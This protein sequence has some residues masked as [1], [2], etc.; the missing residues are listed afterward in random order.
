MAWVAIT[1]VRLK[2][3]GVSLTAVFGED[4][5]NKKRFL[6]DGL[7]GVKTFSERLKRPV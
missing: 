6:E 5:V 4:S 2:S 3:F 1:F 7:G